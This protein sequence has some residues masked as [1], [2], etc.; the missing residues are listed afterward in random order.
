[1]TNVKRDDAAR[2]RRKLNRDSVGRR[3]SPTINARRR[4][5]APPPGTP[6]RATQV[7]GGDPRY[8]YLA[9]PHD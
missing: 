9:E 1:M 8:A 4:L 2:R 5:N 3:P 6:F 7:G